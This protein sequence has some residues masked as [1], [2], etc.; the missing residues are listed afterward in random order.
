[1]E[2]GFFGDW[3]IHTAGTVPARRRRIEMKSKLV[4][5]TLAFFLMAGIMSLSSVKNAYAAHATSASQNMDLNVRIPPNLLLTLGA[6]T[7]LIDFTAVPVGSGNPASDTITFDM[8]AR[9]G[10]EGSQLDIQSGS[11]NMTDGVNNIP[12]TRVTADTNF[13]SNSAGITPTN[14]TSALALGSVPV[15]SATGSGNAS[16]DLTFTMNENA[17][18]VPSATDYTVALTVILSNP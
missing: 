10:N 4:I 6:A 12:V 17:A 13:T 8:S 9:I 2:L 16:G 11:A 7:A 3:I 14:G 1:M 18:D 5:T 15:G